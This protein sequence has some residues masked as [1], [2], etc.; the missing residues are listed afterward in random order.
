[1]LK[2]PMYNTVQFITTANYTPNNKHEVKVII[3]MSIKTPPNYYYYY[4]FKGWLEENLPPLDKTVDTCISL[5][6]LYL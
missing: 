6:S 5:N 3:K 2:S 4:Y 1:M